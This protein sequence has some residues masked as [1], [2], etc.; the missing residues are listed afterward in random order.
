MSNT[1]KATS[2]T[3]AKNLD[4][5]LSW[6]G[7]AFIRGA[8]LTIMGREADPTGMT[9]YLGRLL[10]GHAKMGL[11]NQLCRSPEA[12]AIGIGLPGLAGALARYRRGQLKVVGRLFRWLEGTEG[13][14]PAER[15]QRA[16]EQ[17]LAL[18]AEEGRAHH[19]ALCAAI[20]ELR[21]VIGTMPLSD[22][23]SPAPAG[24]G[25]ADSSASPALLS[26]RSL[27]LYRE[28][29]AAVTLQEGVGR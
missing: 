3:L 29:Q 13:N 24:D 10:A 28:L 4:E 23:F 27:P 19:E 20:T 26:P 25:G 8:Y 22:G 9:Y 12:R 11:I 18:L 14:T 17:Q 7:Q 1:P 5:L 2:P 21:Y 15:R 16:V 6:Q